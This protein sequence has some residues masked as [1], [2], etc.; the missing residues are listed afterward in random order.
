[1]PDASVQDFATLLSAELDAERKRSAD[2]V[3]EVEYQ[4]AQKGTFSSGARV[5]QTA[6]RL[7]AGIVRYRQ[8]IFEKWT[9]YIRPRMSSLTYADRAAFVGVALSALDAAIE[10]AKNHHNSRPGFSQLTGPLAEIANAGARQRGLLEAEANLHMTTP[11][12]PPS[13]TVH[14]S[15]RGSNSPINV[16]SGSLHQQLPSP[17]GMADLVFAISGLLEAMAKAPRPELA[18]VAEILL[19]A[20]EEAA[21]PSPHR[22]KLSTILA[23]SKAIV[24]TAAA[25]H[26]AWQAV[27]PIPQML[28]LA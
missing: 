21:E 4:F 7:S 12:A 3:S 27:Y 20:K 10:G 9:S 18:D 13:Q 17:E 22:L 5:V 19:E 16:G 1:M 2:E 24:Q 23:G 15:P 6:E 8:C 11:T 28:G 14:V 26:P 25:L